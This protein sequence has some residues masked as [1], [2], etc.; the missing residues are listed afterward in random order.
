MPSS[1]QAIEVTYLGF[2]ATESPLPKKAGALAAPASCHTPSNRAEGGLRDR[3]T[4]C[5]GGDSDN[6]GRGAEALLL[7]YLRTAAK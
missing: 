7:G 2:L 5:D 3:D 4:L 1:S 6:S